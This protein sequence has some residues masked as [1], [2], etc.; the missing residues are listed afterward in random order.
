MTLEHSGPGSH[1][2][3]A[4]DRVE[5]HFGAMS[6]LLAE[7]SSSLGVGYPAGMTVEGALAL[8][9]E[10]LTRLETIKITRAGFTVDA[11][12]GLMSH[13]AKL[14]VFQLGR[15]ELGEDV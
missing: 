15:T 12:L 5:G 2:R 3:N 13:P 14:G 9:N 6:A 10:Q 11:W 8:I 7:L 1:P 4:H